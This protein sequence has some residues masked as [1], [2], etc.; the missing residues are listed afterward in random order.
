MFGT[1]LVLSGQFADNAESPSPSLIED[2]QT[3]QP[4]LAAQ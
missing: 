3:T 1:Q 2:L 4:W